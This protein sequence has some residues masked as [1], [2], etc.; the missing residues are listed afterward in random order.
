MHGK[1]IQIVEN[2]GQEA[3][4]T[5]KTFMSSHDTSQ[6]LIAKSSDGNGQVVELLSSSATNLLATVYI[7]PPFLIDTTKML[8][9]G[10]RFSAF[11][12]DNKFLCYEIPRDF[13]ASSERL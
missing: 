6:Q 12:R 3:D 4:K 5:F 11:T 9:T 2:R 13:V 10:T 7:T 8:A 1:T